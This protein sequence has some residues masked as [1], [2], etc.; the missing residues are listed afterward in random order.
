LLSGGVES[1]SSFEINRWGRIAALA[2]RNLATRDGGAASPQVGNCLPSLL[3]GR[4][5]NRS[6]LS[7]RRLVSPD[8]RSGVDV[9]VFFLFNRGGRTWTLRGGGGV[10]G[11]NGSRPR[12]PWP[13]P[14]VF[15]PDRSVAPGRRGR[16]HRCCICIFQSDRCPN[17]MQVYYQYYL[18]NLMSYL[19][20]NQLGYA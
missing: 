9:R 5:S 13:A 6:T 19:L 7:R 15:F 8:G 3:R 4:L 20:G 17:S 1:S 14:P 16:H 10:S 12:A 18:I 11:C 2:K